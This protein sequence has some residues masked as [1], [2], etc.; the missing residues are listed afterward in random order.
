QEQWE[1]LGEVLEAQVN[2]LSGVAGR[3]AALRALRAV[4]ERNPN[5]DLAQQKELDSAIL[6]L[7]PNDLQAL[8]NLA[9]LAVEQDDHVL[10]SQVDSRLAV[11]EADKAS[12]AAHQT[13]LGEA[14]EARGDNGAIE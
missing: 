14:M 9:A 8:H 2:G 4:R 13:R 6:R 12:M 7:L 3:V 1:S 10:L 11:V 5:V